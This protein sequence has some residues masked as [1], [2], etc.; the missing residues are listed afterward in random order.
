MSEKGEVNNFL[1]SEKNK[2]RILFRFNELRDMKLITINV[3]LQLGRKIQ[4]S[5]N[6]LIKIPS[7]F[8]HY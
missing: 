7:S 4:L 5:F 8:Y 1:I 3:I 6:D 2:N